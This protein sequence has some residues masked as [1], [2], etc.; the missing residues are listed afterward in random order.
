MN[1]KREDE[2]EVEGEDE[3]NQ[4]EVEDQVQQVLQ[5]TPS[6]RVQKNHPSDHIIRNKDAGVEIRRRINS[7]EQMHLALSSMI[8]P[9]SFEEANKDE[10]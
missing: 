10:F 2:E 6:K 7:P 4:T 9:N 3:E 1:K 5:K 8:E